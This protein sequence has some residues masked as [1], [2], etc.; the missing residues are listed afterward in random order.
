M[1]HYQ[2][3]S[4]YNETLNEKENKKLAKKKRKNENEKK[5]GQNNYKMANEI[6]IFVAQNNAGGVINSWCF[7]FHFVESETVVLHHI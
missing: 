7:L 3:P 4:Q 1:H 2:Q 6:K 5:N